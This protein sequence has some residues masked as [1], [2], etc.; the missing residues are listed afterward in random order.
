MHHLRDWQPLDRH[1]ERF[2]QRAREWLSF[3][4]AA[5]V[6]VVR[7]AVR[8]DVDGIGAVDCV[9]RSR[10]EMGA[11]KGSELALQRKRRLS[12]RIESSTTENRRS[13]QCRSGWF[14][15]MPKG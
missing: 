3:C 15:T 10:R 4:E 8:G 1:V 5:Q 9:E 12:V 6:D 11:A 7:L 13:G 14:P 2:L